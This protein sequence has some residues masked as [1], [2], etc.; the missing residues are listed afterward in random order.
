LQPTLLRKCEIEVEESGENGKE[1]SEKI[2]E[3]EKYREIEML[4]DQKLRGKLRE[5]NLGIS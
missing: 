1:G 3:Q 5:C 2:E 4:K